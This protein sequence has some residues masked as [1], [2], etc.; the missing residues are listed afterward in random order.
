MNHSIINSHSNLVK[1]NYL[2]FHHFSVPRPEL[3]PSN[4]FYHTQPDI[5]LPNIHCSAD[6][7]PACDLRWYKL[8]NPEVLSFNGTLSLG[9]LNRN[10]SGEY[11]CMAI[12][13]ETT[14]K[15]SISFYILIQED[16]GTC[17]IYLVPLSI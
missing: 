14:E 3:Q 8:G 12:N 13:S 5:E 9:V 6:C 15:G 10:S 2:C 1:E 16:Q 4:T 7:H 11:T 17:E